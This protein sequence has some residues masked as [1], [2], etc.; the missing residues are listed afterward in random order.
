MVTTVWQARE[1]LELAPFFYKRWRGNSNSLTGSCP[2]CNTNLI[3]N[4]WLVIL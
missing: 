2:L 4:T 1:M 3:W